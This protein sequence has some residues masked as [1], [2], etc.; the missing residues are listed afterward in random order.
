MN[1]EDD[2][3]PFCDTNPC[4][5]QLRKS[6][7]GNRNDKHEPQVYFHGAC[8]GLHDTAAECPSGQVVGFEEG[9]LQPSCVQVEADY[10]A[11]S[12]GRFTVTVAKSKLAKKI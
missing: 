5:T 10:A 4:L 9:E 2:G 7:N 1:V 8:V 3:Q 11:A 12:L 6:G